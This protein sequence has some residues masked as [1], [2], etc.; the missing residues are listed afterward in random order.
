MSLATGWLILYC[1]F[2]THPLPPPIF[3]FHLPLGA[4]VSCSIWVCWGLWWGSPEK[5]KCW[6]LYCSLEQ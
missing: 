3:L 5:R 2:C 6:D 4:V 1:A